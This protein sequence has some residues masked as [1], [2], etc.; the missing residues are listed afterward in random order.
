MESLSFWLHMDSEFMWRWFC[1]DGNRTIVA[2][3]ADCYFSCDEAK[4][5]IIAAKA[6]MIQAA[7][8]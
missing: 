7:A 8:A 2:R 6:R 5:A 4:A 3:S 1:Y